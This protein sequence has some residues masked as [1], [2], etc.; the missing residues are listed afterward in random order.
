MAGNFD[1]EAL[2]RDIVFLEKV[3]CVKVS[4]IYEELV[5]LY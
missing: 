2:P 1:K 4:N 3:V 5:Y